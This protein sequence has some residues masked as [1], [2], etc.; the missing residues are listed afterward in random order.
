[1][2][3]KKIAARFL[4]VV[5]Y[6]YY[7]II[8]QL[9]EEFERQFECLEKNKKYWEIRNLHS[10]NRKARKWEDRKIQNVIHRQCKI[11]GQL[12]LNSDW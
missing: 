5:K 12:F 11:Y 9:V 2:T 8:K 3:P 10:A 6:D 1:M 4:Q 7:F